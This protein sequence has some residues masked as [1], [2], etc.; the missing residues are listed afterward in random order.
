MKVFEHKD[1]HEVTSI[2][3]EQHHHNDSCALNHSENA[4]DSA[5]AQDTNGLIFVAY[6]A[7][8]GEFNQ[9]TFEEVSIEDE[10]SEWHKAGTELEARLEELRNRAEGCGYNFSDCQ[11]SLAEYAEPE[12]DEKNII[13][14]KS[15]VLRIFHNENFYCSTLEE[16]REALLEYCRTN[17][18]PTPNEI[19][20][21]VNGYYIKWN[22]I[23]GFKGSEIKLW[24]FLQKKLHESFARINP[25]ASECLNATAM[26]PVPG[27]INSNYVT[28]FDLC[29]RTTLVYSDDKNYLSPSEFASKLSLSASEITEYRKI[30]G[31]HG[32]SQ[33]LRKKAN[34]QPVELSVEPDVTESAKTCAEAITASLRDENCTG[35]EYR[36]YQYRTTE[37]KKKTYKWLAINGFETLPRFDDESDSWISAATYYSRF[38][39]KGNIA[40]INC[41]FL[42]IN[43]KNFELEHTPTPEQGKELVLSRCRELGL[44]EPEIVST[45]DGLEV[46]WYWNDRMTKIL[47][48]HDPYHARFNNDWEAIQKK[49]YEKFW[50]LGADP[51]KLCVTVMF[52][53]P[54]SKDTRKTLKKS[55]DRIIRKIHQGEI[56][57]S[58]RDIQRALGIKETYSNEQP[59]VFDEVAKQKWERFSVDNPEL[60]KDWETDVLRIHPSSQN[61]V[62][63]GFIDANHKWNNRW[64]QACE[65]RKYLLK[66]IYRPEFSK[67]DFYVSQGE[68]LSRNDRTLK[69]LASINANFVDLDYKILV[70]YRPEITENPSP[71][72]WENLVKTHCEKFG[73][74]LPNDVVFTGGGVHLKWIYDEPI[75]RS[76]LELWQ[77]A[78]SLLLS[79]FKTLGADP[80]SSD[81][82]RVLR[83]VGSENHKDSPII[84]DRIVHVID[85]EFF[86]AIRVTLKGLVEDLEKSQP[87]NP[88]EFSTVKAEW[89]KILVQLSIQEANLIRPEA[90][91][92][93]VNRDSEDYRLADNYYWLESTLRHHKLHATY[94]EAEV[95]GVKK[96][97]E[98]YHLHNALRQ[99]FGM[100]N[101]RLSLSE[102]KGQERVEQREAIEWIPCNYV[103][104]SRCPGVT[105]EEQKRNIFA[106]C[107]EYRDVGFPEPNQ[108]IRI[109]GKLL[110]EWTYQSVLTGLALSRWQDTQ[111]FICRH[112]E[113]WGAMDDPEYLKATA[114][115]PVPGFEYDGEMA[116]LEYSELTKRYT[117]NRLAKAVLH[118]SQ[119]EVEEYRKRKA[120]EKAKREQA[121]GKP[122]G[123]I[124]LSEE[125]SARILNAPD[126]F[127][128]QAR[129]TRAIKYQDGKFL[130]MAQMRYMDIIHW[131]DFQRGSDGEIPQKTR[132][133]CVFW[134]LVFAKQAGLIKTWAEFEAKAQELVD[135]CGYQFS[136]ECTVKTLKSA[137]TK[138]Y[139]ATTDYLIRV[140]Q[141]TP[142]AQ[143]QMKVLCVGVKATAKERQP[144]A[145][146][147]AEHSQERRKPWEDLGISRATYFNRK[148]AGTLPSQVEDK[149]LE[150]SQKQLD[151]CA[152]I[153]SAHI[154]SFII[155]C[156]MSFM[157]CHWWLYHYCAFFSV[158]LLF[159]GA[160]SIFTDCLLLLILRL[161]SS[162]NSGHPS[163][164]RR[165]SVRGKRKS[166]KK[167][168]R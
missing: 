139:H 2:D 40:S 90:E 157:C 43:W 132:E 78:Q 130:M 151:W 88:D 67:C 44:P 120:E 94:L 162:R 141:I 144:R 110:V 93:N 72:E 26:I 143:K 7:S 138:E 66:L 10:N 38:R 13:S 63:F 155:S 4:S 97:I 79:Q 105:L 81:A 71:E 50:Y 118:F 32:K 129:K 117:F 20:C 3:D 80:A 9:E 5:S 48:E 55:A 86:S 158:W 98:T 111:E 106:R 15:L 96:Y 77:Y 82:A 135:F 133:L 150:D 18:I 127:N 30:N 126:D 16:A 17:R 128:S 37:T 14:I 113:D 31:E 109:G 100:P 58:Y 28:P 21:V 25:D 87:E 119:K 137:Y 108:I 46:K 27:F 140:L 57:E 116:R 136:K 52:R 125:V 22:F 107:H 95:S 91:V 12:L 34:K 65:L 42:I 166:K 121:R 123:K 84:H 142:E 1:K 68:F 36:Y 59:E 47:Y 134:A 51:K 104:L 41:N 124:A 146:W 85:R 54:G 6:V 148:K 147:L 56:A 45:P 62:C 153:M 76:E 35:E 89:Q 112:F 160:T 23:N 102:L 149:L 163:S 122:T 24:K 92:I 75:S 161:Y 33:R 99:L 29:D 152:Y 11:V 49:L 159:G 69:N 53:V 168:K 131:L 154:I 164:F 114:L 145:E 60:A 8:Y 115:L 61:W 167:R 74:P 19:I 70:G 103:M 156:C 101:V 83:L 39:R 165:R 73:I 64:T